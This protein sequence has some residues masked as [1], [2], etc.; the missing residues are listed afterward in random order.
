M[1]ESGGIGL[2]GAYQDLC[3]YQEAEVKF[4]SGEELIDQLE[5]ITSDF[6]RYM[7]LSDN[8]RKFT[9]N[10]WL[11]DHIQE[12]YALYNTA[13]GSKERKEIAPRLIE[14]NPDQDFEKKP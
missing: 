3:T 2:P 9:E 12:Y 4:K 1:V 7:R 8:A 10:L 13:W 6:D 5:Y 11:E 14:N